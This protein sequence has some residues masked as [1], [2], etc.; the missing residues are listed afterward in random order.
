LFTNDDGRGGLT[1]LPVGFLKNLCHFVCGKQVLIAMLFFD[2][3]HMMT[4]RRGRFMPPPL[5]IGFLFVTLLQTTFVQLFFC[6]LGH[7]VFG[8][9]TFIVMLLFDHVANNN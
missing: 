5:G 9:Q 4:R 3:L 6:F 1:N 2:L 7:F 8:K